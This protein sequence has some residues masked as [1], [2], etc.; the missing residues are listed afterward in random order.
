MDALDA[1]RDCEI[2]TDNETEQLREAW[3]MATNARN[4]L[5]LVRGKRVDQL[6]Q[7]G[8][9]LAQVAGVAGWAPEDNQEFLEAYLKATRHARRVV[10]QVFWGEPDSYEYD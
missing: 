8:N 2:L 7:P 4:A 5:V 3:L 10:D 9:H 1:L 6:P